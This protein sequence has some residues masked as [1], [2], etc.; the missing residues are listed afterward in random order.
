MKV[1]YYLFTVFLGIVLAVHLAMNGRVGAALGN[2]RVGNA[3][4]WSIGAVT[5]I[6]IGL[7]GWR[8]GALEG[9]K[10]IS[11]LLLTAGALGACL[12][13]AIAWMLPN[14][15]ARFMFITLIA[16][17]ILGGMIL[18]HYGW[19]GSPVERITLTNV[20]GAIIMLVGVAVAT[21][22]H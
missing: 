5:A 16:G 13:F 7:T 2:P 18:S 19:L 10:G 11:P 21:Y 3:V 4:F 9:L 20:I 15:G 17:Q 22:T 12:V 1:A 6:L 14:V 8:T